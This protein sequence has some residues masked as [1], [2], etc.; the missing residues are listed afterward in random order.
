MLSKSKSFLE[1]TLTEETECEEANNKMGL[2]KSSLE[3]D[4]INLILVSKAQDD[5]HGRLFRKKARAKKVGK[6]FVCSL[7]L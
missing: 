7:F 4:M 5:D 1:V 6:H 3:E 2:L